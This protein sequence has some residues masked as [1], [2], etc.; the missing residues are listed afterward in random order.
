MATKKKTTK[1]AN[2]SQFINLRVKLPVA[3]RVN[4]YHEF[5]S[6]DEYV[7][8]LNPKLRCEEV[9]DD[10]AFDNPYWGIFYYGKPPSKKTVSKLLEDAGAEIVKYEY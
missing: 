6:I 1:K 2:K 7:K 10:I 4:D 3:V 5:D 9:S 8:A